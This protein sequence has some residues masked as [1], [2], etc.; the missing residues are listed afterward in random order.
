MRD[1]PGSLAMA[2]M[3]ILLLDRILMSMAGDTSAPNRARLVFG[4]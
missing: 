3:L 4:P 2:Q 1:T